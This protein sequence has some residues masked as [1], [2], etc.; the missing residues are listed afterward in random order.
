MRPDKINS[1]QDILKLSIH[2]EINQSVHNVIK[3]CSKL[4]KTPQ[5]P[6]FVASM[7][8]NFTPK[9][10]SILKHNFPKIKFSV[11]GIFCHQKPIVDIGEA[12]NPEL[13]D[14]LFV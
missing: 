2:F 6:D 4:K 7:T 5:E 1:I 12:K 13:G 3:N 8:L 10:F 9:L 11:T 14:I